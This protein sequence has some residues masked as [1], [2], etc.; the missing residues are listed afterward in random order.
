MRLATQGNIHTTETCPG[1]RVQ[2]FVYQVRVSPS[3][4][5]KV[6]PNCLSRFMAWRRGY[7]PLSIRPL[8]FRPPRRASSLYGGLNRFCLL[9]RRPAM[10]DAIFICAGLAFFA[11]TIGYTLI[12]EKL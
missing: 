3:T 6:P 1:Q 9:N 10:W 12:C 8:Y 4:W 11:A 5:A 2:K 7:N